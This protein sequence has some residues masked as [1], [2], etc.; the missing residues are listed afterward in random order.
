MRY[1]VNSSKFR[2][3][4][5]K[6]R[7]ISIELPLAVP[8]HSTWTAHRNQYCHSCSLLSFESLLVA[9]GKLSI[10]FVIKLKLPFPTEGEKYIPRTMGQSQ[11]EKWLVLNAVLFQCYFYCTKKHREQ[12]AKSYYLYKALL[13]FG[14]MNTN[15][16]SFIY[17]LT[18]GVRLFHLLKY[19]YYN[20]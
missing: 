18:A 12:L 10:S 8:K 9:A 6:R 4:L 20:I 11:K 3:V 19:M 14:V 5:K 2:E 1:S 13:S 17:D 7:D 15:L 16:Y